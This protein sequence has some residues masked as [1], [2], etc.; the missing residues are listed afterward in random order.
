M[1]KEARDALD[2][3]LSEE[4]AI[5][6]I[7]DL[8]GSAAVAAMLN[9]ARHHLRA[10]ADDGIRAA[11]RGIERILVESAAGLSRISRAANRD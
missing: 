4:A 11:T 8:D 2:R 3:C 5:V 9:E 10:T 6:Q 7:E 1:S